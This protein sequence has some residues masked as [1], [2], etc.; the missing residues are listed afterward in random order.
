MIKVFFSLINDIEFKS[1]KYSYVLLSIPV[2]NPFHGLLHLVFSPLFYVFENIKRSNLLT[3]EPDEVRSDPMV[4]FSILFFYYLFPVGSSR[5]QT[6]PPP[7]D[8]VL[9][10]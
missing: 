6:S 8:V 9:V 5:H 4:M 7:D 2:F 10:G 3:V 1:Q